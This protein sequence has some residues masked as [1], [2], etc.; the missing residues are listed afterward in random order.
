[1][2]GERRKRARFDHFPGVPMA[3]Q[4]ARKDCAAELLAKF[5]KFV[6]GCV[7]GVR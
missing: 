4:K 7:V 5:A 6:D 1:M 3:L 2:I